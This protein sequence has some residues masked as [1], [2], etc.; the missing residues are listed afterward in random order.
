MSSSLLVTFKQNQ[1]WGKKM[2][3]YSFSLLFL[4]V[5]SVKSGEEGSE[6]EKQLQSSDST[7]TKRPCFPIKA[8]CV[9]RDGSRVK[10]RRTETKSPS[11]TRVVS[12]R[13]DDGETW[14]AAGGGALTGDSR[15]PDR[16]AD[17]QAERQTG[18]K[19]MSAL[20][21]FERA[22]GELKQTNKHNKKWQKAQKRLCFGLHEAR[23]VRT[24]TYCPT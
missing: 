4:M 12:F 3:F 19:H 11:H 10:C 18:L 9:T 22:L 14:W 2:S 6:R 23:V 24:I 20:L 8:N 16:Q 1:A 15:H 13:R 17:R 7:Q 21:L 5:W